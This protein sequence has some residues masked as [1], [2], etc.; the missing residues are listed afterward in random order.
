MGKKRTAV[1]SAQDDTANKKKVM[2]RWEEAYQDLPV[3]VAEV[4]RDSRVKPDQLPGM[5]DGEILALPAM[6]P[7]FLEQI[8]THYPAQL[9]EVETKEEKPQK[10]EAKPTEPEVEAGASPRLKRPRHVHGRSKRYKDRAVKIEDKAHALPEAVELL[11]QV[12]YSKHKTIELHLVVREASM[13]GELSLPHSTGKDIKVEIFSEALADK[14]KA[15]KLDF[16]IL[17]AKPEDMPKVAPLA[18]V[19]GPRGLM[20]NPKSGTVTDSPEAR[21][22]ELSTGATL[23][24]KTEAKAPIVHL[25]VGNLDQP[26]EELV[27]NIKAVIEAMGMGKV[28]RATLKSTMSPGISLA[29]A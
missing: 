21:A 27:A 24:Y 22:K 5:S 8:R 16:D 7:Q 10:V 23:A 13:R 2:F 18:K 9:Q 28:I 11:K 15:G 4:L 25:V 19:L 26:N 12:A 1:V 20:P 3:D 29:L 6:N 17:L 14:I